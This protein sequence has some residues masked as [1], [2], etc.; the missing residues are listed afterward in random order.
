LETDRSLPPASRHAA[1]LEG[2]AYF[3]DSG[4][5]YVWEYVA[6]KEES[7]GLKNKKPPWRKAAGYGKRGV[8]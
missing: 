2:N 1:T 3:A 5:N 7:R 8:F 4:R 6:E